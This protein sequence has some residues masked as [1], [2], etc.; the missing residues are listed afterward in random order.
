MD[1]L[2]QNEQEKIRKMSEK[3]LISLLTRAGIDPD[4]I[5]AMDRNTMIERWAKLVSV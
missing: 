1:L 3:R 4:E 5:D 2:G